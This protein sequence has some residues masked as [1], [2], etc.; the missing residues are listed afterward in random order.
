MIN[1]KVPMR[2]CI[3]C[4]ESKE[5]RELIRIVKNNEDFTLDFTGKLNGRGAYICNND[6]CVQK[7]I[8]G[9]ILSKAF[10][11]NI[12]SDTYEKIKEQYFERKQN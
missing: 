2:M 11:Q 4:K 10:K 5:K 3:A 8:K 7:C 12:S 1:K 6:D 9:K